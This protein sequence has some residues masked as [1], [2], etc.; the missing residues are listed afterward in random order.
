[1]GIHA[2][3]LLVLGLVISSKKNQLHLYLKS[4]DSSFW[5]LLV[6]GSTMVLNSRP[7]DKM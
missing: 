5:F 2:V 1:M 4:S 7:T 3:C 6:W